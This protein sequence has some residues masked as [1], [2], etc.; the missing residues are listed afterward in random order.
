[1]KRGY[2]A[3]VLAVCTA[4]LSLFAGSAVS[5]LTENISRC[6]VE[7]YHDVQQLPTLKKQWKESRTVLSLF[8]SHAYLEPIDLLLASAETV[9]PEQQQEYCAKILSCLSQISE[10]T[11]LSFYNIF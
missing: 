6:T 9:P 3:L 10:N 4:L 7:A 1:M 2:I 11:Q 8:I 5:R